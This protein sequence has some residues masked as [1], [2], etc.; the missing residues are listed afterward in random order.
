MPCADPF[1]LP[2]D[3]KY[4][5]YATTDAQSL[6]PYFDT[7]N[8]EEEG[9]RVF[10][11]DDL[12]NW[13]YLGFALNRRDVIG[14]K[15]FWAPEI[16]YKNGKFYMVYTAEEHLGIAVADRPEGPFIQHDKKWISD[17]KIIDGHFF[18]DD[19]G[20]PYLYYVRLL[21]DSGNTIFGARLKENLLE[22]DFSTERFILKAQEKWETVDC[23]VTEGPFVLKRNGVYYLTY[24]ANHTRC[25]DY[26]V[27][28]ATS[29][30]PLENFKKY[31]NNPILKSHGTAVGVGHH[32]FFTDFTDNSLICVYHSH[33]SKTQFTPRILRFAKTCFKEKHGLS[34]LQI[35][36]K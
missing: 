6:S 23:L 25:K 35:D 15:W 13:K 34:I 5:L 12:E 30:S 24:S 27:G 36:M 19:D 31:E 8:E 11:S 20:T 7:A 32:S 4:Y 1:I 22:V 2:F 3:G 21:P 28:V 10:V 17:E 33:Y 16:A 18:F 9:V 26:A 29:T 14:D